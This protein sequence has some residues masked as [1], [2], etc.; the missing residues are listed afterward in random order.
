[1]HAVLEVKS[2]IHCVFDSGETIEESFP[3]E[4]QSL[5]P[6]RSRH[7]ALAVNSAICFLLATAV[8]PGPQLFAPGSSKHASRFLNSVI[9]CS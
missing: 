7:T 8:V 5:G 1:M 4:E 3:A 9:C 6:G 2:A